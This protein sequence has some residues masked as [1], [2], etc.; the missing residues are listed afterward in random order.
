MDAAWRADNG[1]IAA[2]ERENHKE[3]RNALATK[4]RRE[5]KDVEKTKQAVLQ[6]FFEFFVFFCG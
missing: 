4:K 5:L 1:L 2:K 6:F 3:L